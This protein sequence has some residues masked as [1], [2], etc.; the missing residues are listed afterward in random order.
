MIRGR[1][2]SNGVAEVVYVQP[3]A[4]ATT[5]HYHITEDYSANGTPGGGASLTDVG[6]ELAATS[7]D[8]GQTG[9]FDFYMYAKSGQ[10]RAGQS[11][12]GKGASASARLVVMNNATEW[13][14]SASNITN[15]KVVSSTGGANIGIGSHF[16]L[17]I[18]R[19]F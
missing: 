4:D 7:S 10:F 18:P 2:I 13:Q 9:A 14:D 1:V 8:S 19:T 17:W 15:L 11:R 3:N 5:S 16:E 12:W 6:M